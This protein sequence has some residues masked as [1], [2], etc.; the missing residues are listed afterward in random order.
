[1]SE[2]KRIGPMA[3]AS[4]LPARSESA[5]PA[6]GVAAL[7]FAPGRMVAGKYLVERAIGEGGLGAVVKAKHVQLDQDVAIK[8]IKPSELSRPD[9]VERFLREARLAAKIKNE[10]AVKVQDVDTLESGVPYMV[11]EFLEGRDLGQLLLEGPL[12]IDH[13]IDCLL[14]ACE[15][16][17]EAHA[18]GI[19]HRNL[20]P[21]N[22]FLTP[23]PG[24][25]SLVKVLDFGISRLASD[26]GARVTRI[27]ERIGTPEY[28]SPEQLEAVTD[29]DAR[30]D[31]WSLGV[32]LYE[33]VTGQMPFPAEGLPQLCVAIL[34]KAPVPMGAVHP[35][36]TPPLEAVV[37]R[38]LE[39]DRARRYQNVAELAQDLAVIWEGESP[40]RVQQNRARHARGGREGGAA[41][42]V[43]GL[44]RRRAG[45]RGAR[46][47]EG[48]VAAAPCAARG[49]RRL[50]LGFLG[51][52]GDQDNRGR[53]ARLGRDRRAVG[54]R[55]G[56]GRAPRR[57]GRRHRRAAVPLARRGLRLRLFAGG[58]GG[59]L[60]HLRSARGRARAPSRDL[61]EEPRDGPLG[62]AAPVTLAPPPGPPRGGRTGGGVRARYC[63]TSETDWLQLASPAV[64]TAR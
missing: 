45:R 2:S 32:T 31:V 10:H 22:M 42:A 16:L 8:H 3:L 51:P 30:S 26:R 56:H 12:P 64:V 53:R 41:D 60:R 57:V 34:T 63:T 4:T 58:P 19:V 27:D 40:S 54:G 43:P 59:P 44:N 38:C 46:D 48:T 7:E 23:R 1:M 15:A 25:A 55:P 5:I 35:D 62:A 61:R 52:A 6:S 14:Q 18:I 50:R 24:G 20:K 47:G 21:A 49:R 9:V 11:M 39:K 36:A 37:M 17:A 33:L 13:A 28:M 29:V